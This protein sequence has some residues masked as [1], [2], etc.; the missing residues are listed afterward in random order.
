MSGFVCL[1]AVG[2]AIG[3][4]NLSPQ[5]RGGY[6]RFTNAITPPSP[7]VVVTTTPRPTKLIREL[8]AEPNTIVTRGSSY[9]NRGNLAPAFFEQ[10]IRKYEGT[11]LGRQEIDAELLEDVPGALWT[12]A[13][14][15]ATR[16]PIGYQA[17]DFTRVV[18]AID[19]AVTSGEDADETG[20]IVVAKDTDGRGY[21]LADLSGHM[22]PI[23]WAKA[24]I[25]AYQ[26]HKADRIVAEVNNGGEMV[27]NTLR[28]V[29]PNVP[30][31]A[32]RASRG[33]VVRA[34]PVSALYEQG[35]IKHLGAF[36]KLEDQMCMFTTDLDRS[37]ERRQ[38][39]DPVGQRRKGDSPDRV[40]AL[41]WGFTEILVEPMPSFGIFEATRLRAA[42]MN[43]AKPV[44]GVPVM[45][46]AIGSMEYAAEQAAKARGDFDAP[47]GEPVKGVPESDVGANIRGRIGDRIAQL[48]ATAD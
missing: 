31:A 37:T 22:T 25:A 33:K 38:A 29:D 36:P 18:V 17:P 4:R 20:I 11:R 45:R 35:R 6:F 48:T 23:Q 15:E 13:L 24:A 26:A 46:Y 14:L 2:S 27:E 1:Y 21:V 44:R 9:E 28:M 39:D 43:A 42:A 34:E 10:I 47:N 19:P 8:I 5:I 3:L 32:V 7:R 16:P 12:R 40:D 30:Y 41:V